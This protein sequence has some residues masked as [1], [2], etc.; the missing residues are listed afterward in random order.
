[1]KI[2]M[3]A[4]HY[5]GY[6]EAIAE[7]LRLLGHEVR[8]HDLQPRDLVMRALRV[9]APKLWQARLNKHHST[10][11][12]AERGWAAD[13]VLF[14]QAHQ[15]SHTN[16]ERFRIAFPSARFA[17]YN[18]DS[19]ANHD[20]LDKAQYFDTIQTF[21][22]DDAERHGFLYLPLFA[23]RQFQDVPNRVKNRRSVYFV[24]NIVN[25]KRYTALDN[26]RRFCADHEIS[27]RLYMACT[28]VVRRKLA[29]QKISASG[30]AHGSIDVAEFRDMLE[31]SHAV[32]DFANHAQ[33]GYTMRIFENLC[34]GKKIITNNRR[35]ERETFFSP[36][37]ILV[38]PNDGQYESVPDFLDIP[39]EHPQER[40]SH[41]T[42]QAF[43]VHL[44]DGTGH[45]NPSHGVER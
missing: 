33:S 34:G 45:D 16:F 44:T 12:K 4:L 1:M 42:I 10:I 43:A 41:Y 25:P 24:G 2:L 5:H 28:P 11:L 26:F 20:Y 7:E 27:F 9:T 29:R 31:T 17:L 35:I 8:L 13:L 18:W 14:I 21:D 23:S 40:F 36:D 6:T 32:F 39:I 19:L 30:L 15:M 38:L 37:R 22:P 3:I